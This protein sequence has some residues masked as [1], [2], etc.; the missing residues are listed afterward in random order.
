MQQQWLFG[1]NSFL[2]IDHGYLFP[3]W[4]SQSVQC[5]PAETFMHIY[6]SSLWMLPSPFM[7]WTVLYSQNLSLK[8]AWLHLVFANP[9]FSFSALWV[10]PAA[11][12][13]VRPL[14]RCFTETLFSCAPSLS[15]FFCLTL[16][17][18]CSSSSSSSQLSFRNRKRGTFLKG[19]G[20][21]KRPDRA[22]RPVCRCRRFSCFLNRQTVSEG[23]SERQAWPWETESSTPDARWMPRKTAKRGG[24]Q[25]ELAGRGCFSRSPACNSI[26]SHS[27]S[28]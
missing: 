14:Q 19:S 28:V 9:A 21:M 2:Y 11:G 7:A 5:M 3:C 4:H 15:F 1:G 10:W 22:A 25:W 26:D 24:R 16:A 13:L 12:S 27:S 20:E 8:S 17:S 18:S 23:P 6:H